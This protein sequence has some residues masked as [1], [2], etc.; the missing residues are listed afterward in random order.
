MKE[1]ISFAVGTGRC[2]T[3]FLAN[4]IN[5]EPEFSSVHERFP[6]NETFHRYCKWYGI[7]VDH[8]GFLKQK[9]RE[10]KEDLTNQK[11]SFESSA[12][13]SLSI[14][15]LYHRFNAKFILMVR[16]PEKVINSY[17]KKGW[18]KHPFEFENPDLPLSY[19]ENKDF[20]HFLGRIAPVGEELVEWNDQS[21]IVKLGWYWNAL[22]QKVIDQFANIPESNFRIQKLE[23][24]DFKAYSDLLAFLGAETSLTEKQYLGIAESRPNSFSNLPKVSDWTERDIELVKDHVSALAD[25]FGYS[26]D[27]QLLPEVPRKKGGVSLA[28]S[29]KKLKKLIRKG[30]SRLQD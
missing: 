17:I 2:G 8:E 20:H 19:Q 22:N 9:E 13:L 1:N 24:L 15:E 29:G 25:Q 21:R 27:F 11:F 26:T 18:Y 6:L 14:E 12:F 23:E 16:S 3:K 10:I 5:R 4:V 7:P 28:D 30:I